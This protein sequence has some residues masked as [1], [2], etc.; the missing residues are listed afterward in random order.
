MRGLLDKLAVA[1]QR[2]VAMLY[3]GII[4]VQAASAAMVLVATG[5]EIDAAVQLRRLLEADLRG[6]SFLADASGEHTKR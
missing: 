5:Y 1:Q 2:Q 4:G 3:L 6:R